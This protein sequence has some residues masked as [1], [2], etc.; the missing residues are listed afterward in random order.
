M[1]TTLLS[2]FLA[3]TVLLFAVIS[4]VCK[5]L[6]I[7]YIFL[8]IKFLKSR[9]QFLWY[10]KL[11][12]FK[13]MLLS[14]PVLAFF[15]VFLLFPSSF[16]PFPALPF[17]LSSLPLPHSPDFFC[18]DPARWLVLINQFY[19]WDPARW[20]ILVK[21]IGPRQSVFSIRQNV[22]TR[23]VLNDSVSPVFQ[24]A[25]SNSVVGGLICS[26]VYLSAAC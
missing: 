20:L 3:C 23:R 16:P 19:C 13:L 6:G 7:K 1:W 25:S 5:L 8:E 4:G 21:M 18:W 11:D 22:L 12:N 14:F 10:L 17:L 15:S 9:K 24:F 26:F 2:P